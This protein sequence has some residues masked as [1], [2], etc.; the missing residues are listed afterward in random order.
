MPMSVVIKDKVVLLTGAS[1]G[2]GRSTALLLAGQGARLAL[3]ARRE[4]KLKET[5]DEIKAQGGQAL[6][7][8]AD[9]TK[10]E[11]EK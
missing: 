1:S 6:A 3:V 5:A 11:K 8:K 9:V 10:S 2:I 4:E 7:I